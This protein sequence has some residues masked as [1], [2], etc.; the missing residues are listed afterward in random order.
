[1]PNPATDKLA[2]I[3][4]LLIGPRVDAAI[5]KAKAAPDS[6]TILGRFILAQRTDPTVLTDDVIRATMVGFMLG[7]IPTNNRC[8]GQI[9]EF[10]IRRPDAMAAAVAAARSGDD[11]L[12]YRVLF[13]ALRFRPLFLG[14]TR[15]C[16]QDQVIAAATPRETRIPAGTMLMIST[17]SASFDPRR[18]PNPNK[19]DPDRGIGD[20]MRF[21]W[22]QHW[23][24]GYGI[25][26]A[27]ITNTFKPLLIRGNIRRAAGA[28]G[29]PAFFGPFYEHLFVTYR[30]MRP[31]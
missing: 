29:Q 13:E 20:A 19:F 5:Q 16:T 3:A 31:A 9:M 24:I 7:F 6:G 8:N 15:T 10:L 25:A 17:F 14:P 23:C 11:D 2:G 22:G 4:K 1:M 12:L 18:V 26:I 28:R 27:Q 21:G 30:T